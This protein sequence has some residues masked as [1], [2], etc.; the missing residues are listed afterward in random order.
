M[1][2]LRTKMRNTALIYGALVGQMWRVNRLADFFR[3]AKQS[4]CSR[5]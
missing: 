5:E 4:C 3:C 1:I 2:E